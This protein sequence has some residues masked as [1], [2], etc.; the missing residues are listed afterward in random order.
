MEPAEFTAYHDD[1]LAT[2]EVRH[3]V[4]LSMLM[5][6]CRGTLD[7]FMHWTL[8]GPGQC[9]VTAARR[10]LFLGALDESQCRTLAELTAHVDYLGVIGADST[11][12]WLVARA[13]QL[14]LRFHDPVPQQI[15]S[16]SVTPRYPGAP[17]HSRPVAAQDS[18]LF[19]DWMLAFHREAVPHD[20]PQA[21]EELERIAAGDRFTFWIDKGQPV[22]MAGIVRR[23]RN[24]AAITGVYTPPELRGRGYAGAVTAA[25]VERIYAEGRK[26]ACLYTDLRN[27]FSNRCYARIGFKPVCASMQFHRRR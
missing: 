6:A 13:V 18:T 8:G 14:G 26:T 23:L 3:G 16:I 19:V 5:Q 22:S 17:G 15:H 9:A 2:D 27:P 11:A 24:S 4:I 10:S 7:G 25:V 12:N 20:P 21:R 1:V